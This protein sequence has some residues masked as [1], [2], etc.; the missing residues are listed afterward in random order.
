MS[1]ADIKLAETAEK[2]ASAHKRI[3]RIDGEINSLRESRHTHNGM[4]HN[5]E[6]ILGGM[7][8]SVEKLALTVDNFNLKTSRL[9]WMICGGTIAGSSVVTFFY[10]IGKEV[11]KLW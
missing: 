11:L 9:M 10:F 8:Q 5:H 6:G 4:L 2:A 7:S 1:D 3:D